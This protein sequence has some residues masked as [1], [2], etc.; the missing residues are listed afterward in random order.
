MADNPE[1]GCPSKATAE[2]WQVLIHHGC[3]D[4]P[5]IA[6]VPDCCPKCGGTVYEEGFGLAGG[7]YGSYL[8]CV[9]CSTVVA[10]GDDP[11]LEGE[12]SMDSEPNERLKELRAYA[13]DM[14]AGAAIPVTRE[15]LLRLLDIIED[16][17]HLRATLAAMGDPE[18]TPQHAQ[19]CNALTMESDRELLR[20]VARMF[21]RRESAAL[22][23]GTALGYGPGYVDGRLDGADEP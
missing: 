8:M 13:D 1:R 11:T 4:S 3:P 16:A 20:G 9:E 6:N 18:C 2:T 14:P 19:A 5:S 22:K 23:R 17:S 15:A 21:R 12:R 10:K 7:G